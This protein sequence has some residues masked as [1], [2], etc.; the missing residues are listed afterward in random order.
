MRINK[1]KAN[2]L[3]RKYIPKINS[4]TVSLVRQLGKWKTAHG[5]S[6]GSTDG[7]IPLNMTA[8]AYQVRVYVSCFGLFVEWKFPEEPTRRSKFSAMESLTQDHL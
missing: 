8:D 5:D 6:K 2:N 3:V 7:R 1:E 4:T